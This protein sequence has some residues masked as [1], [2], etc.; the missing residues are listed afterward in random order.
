MISKNTSVITKKKALNNLVKAARKNTIPKFLLSG[1]ILVLGLIIMISGNIAANS[2]YITL[3]AFFVACSLVY[4][5]L[6]IVTV[7]KAPK[8]ILKSNPDLEEGDLHYNFSFKEGSIEIVVFNNAR[9]KNLKYEYKQVKKVNEFEDRYDIILKEHQLL[10]V[11]KSG[12]V[13]EKA[14][15]FFK[16]NLEKNK[17]KI[18]NKIKE[19]K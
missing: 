8:D 10:F 3:G 5:I 18:I 16:I 19:E 17:I 7:K 4:F 14:E 9:K 2:L 6:A 12:F 15:E 13:G 1:V 11:Y